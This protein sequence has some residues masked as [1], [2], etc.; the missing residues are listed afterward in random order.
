MA[1]GPRYV[2]KFRRRREGITD[3]R[4]RIK[5][6]KSKKPRLVVRKT[7]KYI[8]AHIV[9][10]NP[11]GDKTLIFITS[12][13]LKEFG[14][15]IPSFKNTPAAYLTGL[16]IGKLALK[17]GIKEAILDIGRYPSIKGS[18]LYAVLKGALDAG[19][20]IPHSKEILPS[21]D[22][23]KGKHIANY[24]KE[25]LEGDREKLNILFS[26]YMKANIKP[27]SFEKIFEEV[28]AKIEKI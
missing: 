20:K 4:K 16:L 7:N 17:K 18:K 11:K 10:F 21:E 13:K 23:I 9:E 2:V 1:K 6:L 28:K 5:L 14:W 8:I 19:L 27:E 24:M 15:K 22:R 12:K 26:N 25:L 3:Y